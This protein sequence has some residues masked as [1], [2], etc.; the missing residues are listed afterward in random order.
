MRHTLLFSEAYNCSSCVFIGCRSINGNVDMINPRF[1][2]AIKS[3]FQSNYR[4]FI[5]ER[6]SG[7]FL[8]I[9]CNMTDDTEIS[10]NPSVRSNNRRNSVT[11]L[12]IEEN[13]TKPPTC[14]H[15]SWFYVNK[16]IRVSRNF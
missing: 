5:D 1:I 8:S 9:L 12:E 14:F 6:F 15:H 3:Q 16:R 11:V 7:L 10:Q 2:T 4:V 13:Q